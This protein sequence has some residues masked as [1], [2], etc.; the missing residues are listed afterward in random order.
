MNQLGIRSHF[1]SSFDFTVLLSFSVPRVF[2]VVGECGDD[3]ST[4]NEIEKGGKEK[5]SG[6]RLKS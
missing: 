6:F 4:H 1:G 3:K 5:G 2:L